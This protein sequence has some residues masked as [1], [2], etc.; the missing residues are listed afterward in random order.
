MVPCSVV[1]TVLGKVPAVSRE[2][3]YP[4]GNLRLAAGSA[5]ADQRWRFGKRGKL[6]PQSLSL[7]MSSSSFGGLHWVSGFSIARGGGPC[8]HI[9]TLSPPF[10]TLEGRM[11][12]AKSNA[13]FFL[14]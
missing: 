9:D 7:V 8:P 4:L 10:L 2:F 12:V 6:I 1:F 5:K 14:K 11:L 3:F 13:S